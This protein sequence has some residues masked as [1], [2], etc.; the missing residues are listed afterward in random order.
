MR[1]NKYTLRKTNIS[2]ENQWLE[3][4]LSF[5]DTPLKF[6]M[7]PNNGGWKTAFLSGPR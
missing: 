5:W 3:N 6:N 7:A 2:P 1:Q 4:E